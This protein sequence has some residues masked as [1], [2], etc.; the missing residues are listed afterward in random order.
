MGIK[1]YIIGGALT[2]GMAIGCVSQ[3]E[4]DSLVERYNTLER[5]HTSLEGKY[6]TLDGISSSNSARIANLGSTVASI[7]TITSGLQANALEHARRSGAFSAGLSR[8]EERMA[9]NFGYHVLR[10]NEQTIARTETEQRLLD[11][12]QR[13][14]QTLRDYTDM[15][16]REERENTTNAVGEATQ[17]LTTRIDGVAAIDTQNY[18]HAT[19]RI[20][21][22]TRQL[23]EARAALRTLGAQELIL[24]GEELLRQTN[25]ELEREIRRQNQNRKK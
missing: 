9:Q 3:R 18:A 14:E 25:E 10:D 15:R 22:F 6:N 11:T 4:Y 21:Q 2:L 24:S 20:E 12:I 7:A 13:A 16:S 17:N 5:K 8:L 23:Q 1:H 19:A